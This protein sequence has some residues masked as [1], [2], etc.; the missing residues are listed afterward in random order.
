MTLGIQSLLQK[1]ITTIQEGDEGEEDDA[2]EAKNKNKDEEEK[3]VG[4]DEAK[5]EDVI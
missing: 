3:K 2:D 1:K 5:K 4:E